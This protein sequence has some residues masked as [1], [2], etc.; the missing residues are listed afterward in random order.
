MNL[1]TS[2]PIFVASVLFSLVSCQNSEDKPEHS[3]T[4]KW[5][6]AN[7]Q[8]WYMQELEEIRLNGNRDKNNNPV[9]LQ[10]I[11]KYEQ[12]IEILGQYE[13][14]DYIGF[15]AF[16]Q[17]FE[18]FKKTVEQDVTPGT[19]A[20]I[21]LCKVKPQSEV[22]QTSEIDSILAEKGYKQVYWFWNLNFGISPLRVWNQ[23]G[24]E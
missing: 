12:E 8:K 17:T 5:A 7:T 15:W 4:F 6:A 10:R 19:K 24:S 3:I 18:D 16:G 1:N 13:D 9:S 22:E 23:G 20:V 2:G 14:A 21:G 11:L